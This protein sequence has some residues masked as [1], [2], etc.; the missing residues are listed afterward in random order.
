MRALRRLSLPLVLLIGGCGESS[1]GGSTPTPPP[2]Q[3]PSFT[4]SATAS[5]VENAALS[6][7]ATAT[8]PEGSALTYSIAGGADAGRFSITSAGALSFV[9]APNFDLPQDADGD[10]VY[11]VQLKA[12]DGSL[13]ATLDLKVTVTNSREG[14][15]VKR[16]ATGLNQPM[17]L[18]PIPGDAAH[19][20]LIE[21]SGGIYMF[22][23]ADGTRNLLGTLPGITTDGERG[24]LGIAARP[25]FAT[26]K[27]FVVYYTTT[28]GTIVIEQRGINGTTLGS[29]FQILTIPHASAN[30]HNGGWLAFGPDK[31]LYI[32]TGDGGGSG[33]P[34]GNAQNVNSRLGKILRVA[35]NPD[36]FAGAS[37]NYYMPAPGNPFAKGGGDPYVTRSG[38]VTLSVTRSTAIA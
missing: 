2:N 17:M 22:T 27:L 14:I 20:L 6:Y 34:S 10:N 8:D 18:A 35:D 19:M 4:S 31:M 1:G 32:A 29:P 21:R 3:A 12:S 16:I 30:N 9:S 25:D 5:I 15:A 13:S 28:S 24:L 23:L 33:D 11:Q 7:Q 38:C 26:S 37:P 36:P